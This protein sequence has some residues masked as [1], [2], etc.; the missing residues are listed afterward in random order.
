MQ[1]QR[2]A[3]Y[4]LEYSALLRETLGNWRSAKAIPYCL[5][6]HSVRS[7]F[8]VDIGFDMRVNE[9]PDEAFDETLTFAGIAFA[10]EDN[11]VKERPDDPG[12][13]GLCS[14]TLSYTSLRP[15][16]GPSSLQF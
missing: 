11:E 14:R 3:T 8:Y 7:G 12:L 5:E 1:L 9:R 16:C 13:A 15:G 4:N 10:P 2:H 6:E